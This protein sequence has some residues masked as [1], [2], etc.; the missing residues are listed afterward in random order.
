MNI[1]GWRK[2]LNISEQD[3]TFKVRYLGNVQTSVMKGDGC[4][5]RAVNVIW[6]TYTR[7][8]HPGVEMKVILTGSGIK[9]WFSRNFF[10]FFIFFVV[11]S[12]GNAISHRVMLPSWNL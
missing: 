9:V 1:F 8:D 2:S 5:D 7:S 12:I 11:L 6:N 3:P 10:F 4:T